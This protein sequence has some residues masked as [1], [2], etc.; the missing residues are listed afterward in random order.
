M[1]SYFLG[2]PAAAEQLAGFLLA[3]DDQ[4]A[5]VVAVDATQG[6]LQAR[7]RDAINAVVAPI[8][9]EIKLLACTLTSAATDAAADQPASLEPP[10]VLGQA[11]SV[12]TSAARDAHPGPAA[13]VALPAAL[14][15]RLVVAVRLA[16]DDV[17]DKSDDAIVDQAREFVAGEGKAVTPGAIG[18]LIEQTLIRMLEPDPERD[19]DQFLYGLAADLVGE[20]AGSVW[21]RRGWDRQLGRLIDAGRGRPQAVLELMKLRGSRDLSLS[22]KAGRD[23]LRAAVNVLVGSGVPL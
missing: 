7:L 9:W 11:R 3:P 20:L 6:K 13:G 22:T 4:V 19:V 17:A 1:G 16:R 8:E 12:V 14:V 15:R 23:A 10:P 21:G 5:T 2:R 18:A